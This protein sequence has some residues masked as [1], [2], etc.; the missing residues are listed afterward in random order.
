MFGAFFLFVCLLTKLATLPYLPSPPPVPVPD[1]DV[2]LG[3]PPG[4]PR[5]ESNLHFPGFHPDLARWLVAERDVVG[6][7]IDTPSQDRGQSRDKMTHRVRRNRGRIP[8]TGTFKKK[9]KTKYGKLFSTSSAW[10]SQIKK[11]KKKKKK[12]LKKTF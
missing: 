9:K 5:D 4:S 11:K 7:G 1:S 3:Y 8:T 2:Y 10:M 6:V 12:N